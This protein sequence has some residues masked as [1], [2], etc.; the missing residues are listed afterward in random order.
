MNDL[1]QRLTDLLAR[2]A[3]E[4][5]VGPVDRFLRGGVPLEGLR[6]HGD[7][8]PDGRRRPMLMVLT[9]AAAII[10]ILV[11]AIIAGRAGEPRSPV[12]PVG[13][14]D[15]T[16]T[17][18][19]LFVVP[20][21][22]ELPLTTIP[23][24]EEFRSLRRGDPRP[25]HRI[26]LFEVSGQQWYSLD[27][28]EAYTEGLVLTT[29]I[30][31]FPV[32]AAVIPVFYY[33]LPPEVAF[34]SADNGSTR[35][36]QRP[37]NG[38]V[39][40]PAAAPAESFEVTLLDATGAVITLTSRLENV[41]AADTIRPAPWSSPRDGRQPHPFGFYNA[42]HDCLTGRGYDPYGLDAADDAIWHSCLTDAV[43]DWRVAEAAAAEARA[44]EIAA[45]T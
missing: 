17:S 30:E 29:W 31:S 22:V 7:R 1:E 4:V 14:S 26:M 27:V 34:V 41:L 33:N 21:G 20:T 19:P 36:W 25:Q 39:I 5:D 43:A 9:A 44:A 16:T 45:A 24:T 38:V 42:M 13:P 40:M 37:V 28:I 35:Y 23:A 8:P 6:M 15:A 32:F 2:K 11:A 12:A 10:A 18:L 3:D